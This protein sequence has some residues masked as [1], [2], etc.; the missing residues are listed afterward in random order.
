MPKSKAQ[1]ALDFYKQAA[2]LCQTP[3]D[4]HNV[5]FGIGGK[6]GQLFPTREEREAFM[7]SQEFAE[8]DRIRDAIDRSE[9]ESDEG[10]A[11]PRKRRPAA[12]R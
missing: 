5:F 3:R 8:I 12:K 4:L 10:P 2:R 9:E 6:F 11:T 1:Q 7:R